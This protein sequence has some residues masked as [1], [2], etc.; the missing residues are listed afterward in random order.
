MKESEK[1]KFK[2]EM[3]GVGATFIAYLF[4]SGGDYDF[5]GQLGE[6]FL[7]NDIYGWIITGIFLVGTVSS[8]A[9]KEAAHKKQIDK[10]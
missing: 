7:G 5:P 9:L 4:L 3:Y 10:E 1:I 8:D 6:Y 2:A